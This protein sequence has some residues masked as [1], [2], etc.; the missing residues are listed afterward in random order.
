M[1]RYLKKNLSLISFLFVPILYFW[2]PNWLGILGSMPYW[3]LFWLLPWSMLN[4]SFNG[5]FI[6]LSLGLI[7]DAISP[8]I[9]FTQVPGL[10]LC[11]LWFGRFSPC[12]NQIVGH[13]RYGLLCSIGSFFCGLLYML[14]IL[15]KNFSDNNLFV[16]FP[17]IQNIMAQVFVTGLFAPLFCSWLWKLFKSTKEKRFLVSLSKK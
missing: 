2:S 12:E 13:F 11:G 4:G 3:P 10:A 9:S 6:G 8:D 16:Y 5:F 7:L 14:Q 17:S 1:P 15:I